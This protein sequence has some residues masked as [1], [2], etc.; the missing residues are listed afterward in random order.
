M[1]CYEIAGKI[2]TDFVFDLDLLHHIHYKNVQ[3]ARQWGQLALV[4]TSPNQYLTSYW[5]TQQGIIWLSVI[6][7]LIQNSNNADV[8]LDSRLKLFDITANLYSKL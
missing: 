6:S 1:R 2:Q 5:C 8:L 4:V 3:F 7:L